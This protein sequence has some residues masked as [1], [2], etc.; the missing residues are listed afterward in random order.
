MKILDQRHI[1]SHVGQ[2][3]MVWKVIQCTLYVRVGNQAIFSF[4]RSLN[5]QTNFPKN[6]ESIGRWLTKLRAPLYLKE[7]VLARE[8]QVWRPKVQ[9]LAGKGFLGHNERE[10]VGGG[11]RRPLILLVVSHGFTFYFKNWMVLF[12]SYTNQNLTT[13]SRKLLIPLCMDRCLRDR[14][15]SAWNTGVGPT[16]W[17]VGIETPAF[18]CL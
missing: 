8:N 2:I 18:R 12:H 6:E 3:S 4:L 9:K 1:F 13:H 17:R 14:P 5:K 15:I 7:I 11:G 16:L 10:R